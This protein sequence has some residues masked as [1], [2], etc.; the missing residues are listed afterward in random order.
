M[1]VVDDEKE[2][3]DLMEEEIEARFMCR[4]DTATNGLDAFILCQKTAYDLIISDHEMPIMKGSALIIGIRTR[5]NLNQKTPIFMVTAFSTDG[6]ES[7]PELE[8]VTFF[9]KPFRMND[10]MKA[11]GKIL[12]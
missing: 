12:A 9:K 7:L 2:L 1:L 3:L 8:G 5:E 10:F 4:V 6:L 11:A